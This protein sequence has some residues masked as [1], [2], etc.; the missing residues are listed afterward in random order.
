M[1]VLGRECAHVF[2][3]QKR[4]RHSRD[5]V[6]TTPKPQGGPTGGWLPRLSPLCQRIKHHGL[7]FV[8]RRTSHFP[9][10]ELTF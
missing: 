6:T 4:F 1:R 7:S 5:E 2:A 9:E 8:D 10:S 3:A